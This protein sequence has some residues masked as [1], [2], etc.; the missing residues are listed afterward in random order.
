MQDHRA[1]I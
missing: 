1:Q